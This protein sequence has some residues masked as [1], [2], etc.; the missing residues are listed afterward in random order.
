MDKLLEDAGCKAHSLLM[1]SYAKE[2]DRPGQPEDTVRQ[3]QAVILL[4]STSS[5]LQ[6]IGVCQR[7]VRSC[8]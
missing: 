1:Y 8:T 2:T 4:P 6:E 7:C 3:I 5:V